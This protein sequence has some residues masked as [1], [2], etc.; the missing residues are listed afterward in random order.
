VSQFKPFADDTAT[1]AIGEFSA[2]NGTHIVSFY[3]TL[4]ISRDQIG[5][6]RARELR[7]LLS[8]VIATLEADRDLPARAPDQPRPNTTTVEN[9][10]V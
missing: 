8:D 1:L 7:A 5:L 6:T 9:P 2:E 4:D 10:F 3:G